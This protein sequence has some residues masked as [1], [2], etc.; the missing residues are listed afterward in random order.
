MDLRHTRIIKIIQLNVVSN[1]RLKRDFA[2]PLRYGLAKPFVDQ[3][4]AVHPELGAF[5]ALDKES[6]ELRILRLHLPFP[7]NAERVRVDGRIGRTIGPVKINL[8]IDPRQLEV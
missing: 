1:T 2:A 8:R 5:V 3:E 4:L 6:V 7:T